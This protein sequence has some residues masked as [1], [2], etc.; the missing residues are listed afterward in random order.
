MNAH[1]HQ[2]R[3][4]PGV[5]EVARVADGVGGEKAL[6]VGEGGAEELWLLW[7][8]LRLLL[9]GDGGDAAGVTKLSLLVVVVVVRRR[10]TV[11]TEQRER[12]GHDG[13]LA[14]GGR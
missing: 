5:D 12:V 8:L 14:A 13:G 1:Q 2:R 3:P 11:G 7:L 10:R 6:G 9:A 4:Q